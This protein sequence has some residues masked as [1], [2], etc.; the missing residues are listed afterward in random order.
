MAE[1]GYFSWNLLVR[2]GYPG[3]RLVP[4]TRRKGHRE[5]CGGQ[6]SH[7]EL[8]KFLD[9]TN[10]VDAAITNVDRGMGVENTEAQIEE[11]QKRVDE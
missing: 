1:L 8:M 7:L 11:I 10:S 4:E 3:P 2:R 6:H 9:D 5:R